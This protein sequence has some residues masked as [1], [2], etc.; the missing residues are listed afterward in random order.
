M[1]YGTLILQQDTM[2]DAQTMDTGWIDRSDLL[3]S[4]KGYVYRVRDEHQKVIYVGMTLSEPGGRFSAHRSTAD[5]WDL[6]E[7]VEVRETSPAAAPELEQAE[8]H[9]W[10]PAHNKQPCALC[11]KPEPKQSLSLYSTWI[12]L[13]GEHGDRLHPP[14]HD[15]RTFI[16]E[17]ASLIGSRPN[18]AAFRLINRHGNY[19]PG[20]I[21]WGRPSGP[22]P[23]GY[24]SP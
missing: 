17:V 19:E 24:P 4:G 20:N 12:R 5:W 7:S 22:A 18:R 10:H 3:D 11:P 15:Y 21:Y 1:W 9:R 23:K 8:I 2:G 16:R 13:T 6:A 14:W